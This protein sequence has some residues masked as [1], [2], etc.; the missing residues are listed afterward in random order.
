MSLVDDVVRLLRLLGDGAD[1]AL[2]DVTLSSGHVRMLG[3]A[4]DGME[5]A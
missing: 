4:T 1:G 5:A 2:E 3:R